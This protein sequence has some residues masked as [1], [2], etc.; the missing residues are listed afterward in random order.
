[1]SSKNNRDVPYIGSVRFYRHLIL[2]TVALLIIAP[3][4]INIILFS[5]QSKLTTKYKNQKQLV[6]ELEE[7]IL[8]LQSSFGTAISPDKPEDEI[9]ASVKAGF[10]HKWNLLVVNNQI[11]LPEDFT[12][13]LAEVGVRQYVDERIVKPLNQMLEDA[14]IAGMNL[15]INSSY[16]SMEKQQGLFN[17]S[18]AQY[19]AR[20][21]TYNQ[22]F[23]K[24]KRKI[25]LPSES[26]HQTGL[27]VDI[28]RLG[29]NE[30]NGSADT[31]IVDNTPEMKWLEENC[32]NYGFIRRYPKGKSHITGIDYE[33]YCFR[34]VGVE[35]AKDIMNRQITLEEYIQMLGS[36]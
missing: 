16:R 35:E 30:A 14:K 5:K 34:Y 31:L 9:A 10:G 13:N 26:E 1:M 19:V 24:T 28:I 36:Q 32:A 17:T 12:V 15:Y 2:T 21:D 8:D 7:R 20:G 33:P 23:Y 27:M 4:S 3:I 6:L 25:A 22:A 29:E 18:V 11:S